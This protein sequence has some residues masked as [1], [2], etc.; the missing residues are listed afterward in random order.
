MNNKW[1]YY[2]EGLLSKSA[3]FSGNMVQLHIPTS[4][5]EGITPPLPNRGKN[6]LHIVLRMIFDLVNENVFRHLSHYIVKITK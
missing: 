5:H 4:I 6:E 1:A 2:P 3:Y